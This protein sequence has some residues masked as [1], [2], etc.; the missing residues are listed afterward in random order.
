VGAGGDDDD[1]DDSE[2]GG[3]KFKPGTFIGG[4]VLENDSH[5]DPGNDLP[6]L[7]LDYSEA[8]AGS[9]TSGKGVLASFRLKAKKLPKNSGATVPIDFNF[10]PPNLRDT[11]ISLPGGYIIKPVISKPAATIIIHKDAATVAWDISGKAL[12]QGRKKHDATITFE[13][14]IADDTEPILVREAETNAKGAFTISEIPGG[15]YDLTAKEFHYLRG[16][17]NSITLPPSA[18]NVEFDCQLPGSPQNKLRAGDCNDDNAVNLKDLSIL[19]LFFGESATTPDEIPKPDKPPTP[20]HADIDGNGIVDMSDFSLLASNFGEQGVPGSLLAAPSEPLLANTDSNARFFLQPSTG[21]RSLDGTYGLHLGE[22]FELQVIA[23]NAAELRG[24]SLD[25]EYDSDVLQLI[26]D[27]SGSEGAFLKQSENSTLFFA[28]MRHEQR[29][30]MY[31]LTIAASKTGS[32]VSGNGVV[33][34]LR[35]RVMT[36]RPGVVSL[37]NVLVVDSKGSLN[38]LTDSTSLIKAIPHN[39]RLW[40]NYPNPFNPETWI[41]YELAEDAPVVIKIYNVNGQ[42]VKTLELGLKAPGFY[43]DKGQAAYWDGKN[44]MSERVASGVYF[45]LMEAGKFRTAKKMVII[46]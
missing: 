28:Q 1:D 29:S 12:L 26:K 37:N 35:F 19:A 3:G 9:T 18:T 20:W 43:L 17:S 31:S 34:S 2:G 46:K 7:Q 44:E 41:P 30:Q 16:I 45:Y 13:L 4:T 36:K 24:Y 8:L 23:E 22:V 15:T 39:S 32:G 40:Q 25:L 6:E 10:D 11:T 42:R 21:D 27:T 5:G 14:R 33:A 38:R